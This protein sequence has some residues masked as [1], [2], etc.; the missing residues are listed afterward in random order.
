MDGIKEKMSCAFSYQKFFRGNTL[1]VI[2]PHEDDEINI[3]GSLI[4]GARKEGMRVVCVFLTN[5]DYTYIPDVRIREAVNALSVLGVSEKDIIFLGYPDGGGHGEYSVFMHGRETPVRA[6]G[7]TETC[8]GSGISEFCAAESG[9]HHEYLWKNLLRDLENVIRKYLPDGITAIDWDTHPDH[10]MCSLA[11]ERVM[12]KILNGKGNTYQPKVLKAFAYA[13][14]YEGLKDFYRSNL[15]STKINPDKI[16]KK[17]QPDN[18]NF[19]WDRRIRLPVPES[20]RT[21]DLGKNKIFHALTCHMSQKAMRRAEQIINGDQIFWEKRTNNLCFRGNVYASSGDSQYLHDFCTMNTDDIV[22]RETIYRDY[23]WEPVQEDRNPWCRCDFET[24]RDIGAA[25]F[26]GNIGHEGRIL[27]G[28]LIFS[29]GYRVLVDSLPENGDELYVKFP[30]Q[31]DVQWVQFDILEREG[32][33]AG[34]SEWELLPAEAE[35]MPLLKICAD[36]EFAYEWLL[37]SGKMTEIS[38]YNPSGKELQ[39]FMDARA[40]TLQEIN[41]ACGELNKPVHVRA[42]RKDRPDICDEAVFLPGS[43]SCRIG[44][45]FLLNKSRMISWWENQKEKR[46]HHALKKEKQ[47]S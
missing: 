32:N 27:K 43:I 23:L 8:G 30:V 10:R 11:F 26:H 47:K 1:M 17:G 39:W 46:P 29:N 16:L 5:G 20:C 12:G 19:L 4:Y 18:P 21:Q 37:E 34:L 33:H 35:E 9:V 22:E 15:P 14:A 25:V 38:A 40:V 7:R 6:H 24:L 31:K 28:Q 45:K 2:I 42:E 44:K 41:E 3:A 36:D 13:T